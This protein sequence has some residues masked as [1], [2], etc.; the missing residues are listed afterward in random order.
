MGSSERKRAANRK[1]GQKSQGP[2]N[3]AYTRYNAT[4]HALTAKGLTDL[5]DAEGYRRVLDDYTRSLK[6][7]DELSRFLVETAALETVRVR[8]ARR[9]EAEFLNGLMHPARYQSNTPLT[10][11]F[12]GTP[13][14]IKPPTLIDPGLPPS[15][16]VQHFGKL[17]VYSRY[18]TTSLKNFYRALH[19][20]ERLGRMREGEH[21]PAPIALDVTINEG[22]GPLVSPPAGSDETEA[23]RKDG[24]RRPTS[25]IAARNISPPVPKS[26][27]T[28]H[29]NASTA[30]GSE[31]TEASC[32]DGERSP[33]S[34]TDPR[35]SSPSVPSSEKSRVHPLSAELPATDNPSGMKP[36]LPVPWTSRPSPG[37]LWRKS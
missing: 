23:S 16:D 18:E 29:E 6:P 12:K 17:A 24:E 37:P 15:I 28:E 30:A 27:S 5:D 3:T 25:V 32:K 35:D 8:R 26:P 1:N 33:T 36:S 22:S 13:D 9:C 7:K 20:N 19:E 14:E 2:K 31:E 11:I 4:K 34:I 21:V 10:D